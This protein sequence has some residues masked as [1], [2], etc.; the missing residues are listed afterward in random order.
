MRAPRL[1]HVAVLAAV[2]LPGGVEPA[3]AT[4]DLAVTVDRARVETKLGHKFAFESTIAN[5]GSAAARGLIAHLNVLSYDST[6]YVDPE[7]WSPNRTRYLAPIPAGGSTTITWRMQAV[8]AGSIAVYVAVLARGAAVEPSTGPVV[9][10]TIAKRTTLN[11]E[12]ILPLALGIPAT[13]GLLFLAVRL[14]RRRPKQ[15]TVG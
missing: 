4:E 9:N 1:A 2:F 12:G 15:V 10:V 6:V 7:D 14:R 5:H 13:L 11:S 8:N 3:H